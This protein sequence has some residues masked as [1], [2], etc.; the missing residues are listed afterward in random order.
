L[1]DTEETLEAFLVSDFA[2]SHPDLAKELSRMARTP[3]HI[4]WDWWTG[5]SPTTQK[6]LLAGSAIMMLNPTTSVMAFLRMVNGGKRNQH[7]RK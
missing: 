7:R 2:Q 3:S 6:V 1:D 5:L 4:V